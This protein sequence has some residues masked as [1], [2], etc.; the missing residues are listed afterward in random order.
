MAATSSRQGM[1]TAPGERITTAVHVLAAATA[2]MT[3]Y[4][5][6]AQKLGNLQTTFEISFSLYSFK[7]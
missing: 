6:A 4:V 2:R 5:V 7:G 3:A 1:R